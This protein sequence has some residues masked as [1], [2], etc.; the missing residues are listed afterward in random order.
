MKYKNN[1]YEHTYCWVKKREIHYNECC[2]TL[3]VCPYSHCLLN[4]NFNND[5][6]DDYQE[7]PEEMFDEDWVNT[8]DINES[9]DK[10]KYENHF[11]LKNKQTTKKWED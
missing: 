4:N 8:Y 1:P 2:D 11:D 7:P 6:L 5:F 10:N 3:Q 9:E